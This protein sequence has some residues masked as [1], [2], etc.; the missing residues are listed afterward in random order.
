MKPLNNVED[1]VATCENLLVLSLS[2]KEKAEVLAIRTLCQLTLEGEGIYASY[3]DMRDR[4][5]AIALKVLLG[6]TKDKA[7]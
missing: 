2:D 5:N 3:T 7:L 4:V 1:L 6:R